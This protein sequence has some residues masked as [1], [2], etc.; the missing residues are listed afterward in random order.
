[1]VKNIKEEMLVNL[2]TPDES[3]IQK[4]KS[5]LGNR[6][7][8][9]MSFF[10]NIKFVYDKVIRFVCKCCTSKRNNRNTTTLEER[11]VELYLKGE[12][13]IKNE[14]DCISILTKLRYLDVLVSLF[15]DSNQKLLLGF[16]RKNVIQEDTGSY[17]SDDEQETTKD[18]IN[19]LNFENPAAANILNEERLDEAL[20]AFYSKKHLTPLDQKILLGIVSRAPGKYTENKMLNSQGLIDESDSSSGEDS[21]NPEEIQKKRKLKAQIDKIKKAAASVTKESILG[22]SAIMPHPKDLRRTSKIQKF[23]VDIQ[24][25]SD[26]NFEDGDLNNFSEMWNNTQSP[27]V[28]STK[29]NN[30]YVNSKAKNF[31][32]TFSAQNLAKQSSIGIQPVRSGNNNMDEWNTSQRELLPPAFDGNLKTQQASHSKLVKGSNASGG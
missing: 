1:M 6:W 29:K 23:A 4:I 7:R 9:E 22:N 20:E 11:K 13:K 14:L 21:P 8:L 5:Y 19:K 32:A 30:Q 28:D 16:Q 15:L 25:L 24:D 3:T 27:K 26:A 17:S 10:D 2:S 12:R 18:I 31:T